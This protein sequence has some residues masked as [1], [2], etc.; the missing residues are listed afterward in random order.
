MLLLSCLMASP[1][2]CAKTRI[3]IQVQG[4]QAATVRA[5]LKKKLCKVHRCV[6]PRPGVTQPVDA[7]VR[8]VVADRHLE[9]QVYTD[10]STPDVDERYRLTQRGALS[11][12]QLSALATV[13]RSVVTAQ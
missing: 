3:N 10:P 2:L 6:T 11:A 8:G 7:V 4:K 13:L 1:A 12:K 9:L 5:Q